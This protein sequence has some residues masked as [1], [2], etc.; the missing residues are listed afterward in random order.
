[1]SGRPAAGLRAS[2]P[3]P[4][5]QHRHGG[6]HKQMVTHSRHLEAMPKPELPLP[7]LKKPTKLKRTGSASKKRVQERIREAASSSTSDSTVVREMFFGPT[8]SGQHARTPA[9]VTEVGHAALP[10]LSRHRF[11]SM[12]FGRTES[13]H[14]RIER[15]ASMIALLPHTESVGPVFEDWELSGQEVTRLLSLLD[16]HGKQQR[17]L[18]VFE[19]LDAHR[20]DVTKDKF[21]YTRLISMFS[22]SREQAEIALELFDRMKSNGVTPDLIAFNSA[23]TAAAK[24]ERLEEA[25]GIFSDMAPARVCPDVVTYGALLS[26]CANVAA[27]EQALELFNKMESFGIKPNVVT[28]T[29]LMSACQRA[30]MWVKAVEVFKR[31]EVAGVQADLKAYN[32]LISACAVGAEWE[33]AWAVVAG[34]K[35]MGVRPNTVSYNSLIS[36]CERCGECDRA[37][38]VL[39]KMELESRSAG[40]YVRPNT[41]TYNTVLSACGKA[42]RWDEALEMYRL[43]QSKGL[44]VDV[45][46]LSSLMT[47][48]EKVGR[49]KEALE[50]FSEFKGMG[51]VPNVICYNSLI[52]ALGRG[53][54]WEA[55]MEVFQALKDTTD[56]QPDV[57]TY[58]ALMSVC[59]RAGQAQRA[60]EL[61]DEMKQQGVCGNSYVYASLINV[62]ERKG[63]WKVAVELFQAMQEE[64]IEPKSVTMLAR[65]AL[66]TWPQLIDSLPQPV[67]SAARVAVESGIA[68]RRWVNKI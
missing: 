4:S 65:R 36:A 37:I 29:A 55:A 3:G 15:L 27:W 9:P 23:I 68:A 22:Q 11:G 45:V 19:W 59:E 34:M 60:L 46:T 61:Y 41:I 13:W 21:V 66:Y 62:C 6:G 7:A 48:C 32:S 57:V 18:D 50:L 28:Y 53:S 51:V 44:I 42:G 17:A 54:Q 49:C 24:A 67:V 2:L 63:E 5:E 56:Q 30:G 16:W 47:A 26:A 39:N 31:M 1:M 12:E 25:L 58:S 10:G 8:R 40:S 33:K 52:S 20:A 43:M 14:S 64:G 35:R 38:E